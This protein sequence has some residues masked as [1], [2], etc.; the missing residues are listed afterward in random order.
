MADTRT[1]DERYPVNPNDYTDDTDYA[2]RPLAEHARRIVADE[3][4]AASPTFRLRYDT[5]AAA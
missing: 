4:R 5:Q 2:Y 1:A 3:S